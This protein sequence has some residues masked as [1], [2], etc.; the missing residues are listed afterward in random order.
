[1]L[2]GNHLLPT[3]AIQNKK[4]NLVYVFESRGEPVRCVF[5]I[6]DQHINDVGIARALIIREYRLVICA[7]DCG[8]PLR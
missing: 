6:I 8:C 1:M 4:D 2:P 5:R 7:S 3:K